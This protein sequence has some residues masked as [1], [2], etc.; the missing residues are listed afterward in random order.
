METKD[1]GNN[2][3]AGQLVAVDVEPDCLSFW[4]SLDLPG[5]TLSPNRKSY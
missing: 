4:F 2:V 3:L 5:R 1:Y